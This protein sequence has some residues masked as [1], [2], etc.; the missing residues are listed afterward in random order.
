MPLP[1]AESNPLLVASNEASF[2]SHSGYSI[3]A[4]YISG[5]STLF[6][7][8]NKSVYLHE[9]VLN[10]LLRNFSISNWYQVSSAKLEWLIWKKIQKGNYKPIHF[11]WGERDLGYTDLFSDK[12]L[13][14]LCSTFHACSDDLPSVIPLSSRKRLRNL[15]A[16]IIVSE[17]Q[18][19]FFEQCGVESHK[20]HFIPH[21]IDTD[22]FMPKTNGNPYQP[23]TVLSVGSYRRNFAYLREVF[24]QLKIS[25][26]IRIK[27]VSSSNNHN[28]FSDLE[29]VEFISN[30]SD[31]DL[32]GVYQSASCQIISVEN[33][34]ANNALLEGLAC[35]LPVISEKV[36]GIPEYVNDECSVLTEVGDIKSTVR[37]IVE[38][39]KSSSEYSNMTKASRKRALELSWFNTAQK[40]EEVYLSL[41]R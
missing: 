3:V 30:V 12:N 31:A 9:R 10:K 14:P 32:L 26:D 36:G 17:T 22:F 11:L 33:A 4:K 40:M 8:R 25:K 41:L 16:V 24:K 7:T 19:E 23:F 20:I 35:G 34:T 2:G 28:Y 27:V 38:L 39:S 15:A 5:C 18:R 6:T 1:Y 13:Q 37:A 21:G 29:N